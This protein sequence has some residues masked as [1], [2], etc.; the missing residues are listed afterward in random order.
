MKL[1][2]YLSN[3]NGFTLVELMITTAI[4]G[5]LAQFVASTLVSQM[6]KYRLNGATRQV[7]WDLMSAR[8]QAI[9]QSRNVIVTFTNNHEY[10]IGPDLNNN[11]ALDAD[12]LETKDIQAK[13]HH[14]TFTEPLPATFTFSPGGTSDSSRTITLTNSNESKSIRVTIVGKIKIN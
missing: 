10:A 2:A 8:M 7:A 3:R 5:L 6:P 1:A 4:M 14:V 12:E 11:G 13:H 9:K